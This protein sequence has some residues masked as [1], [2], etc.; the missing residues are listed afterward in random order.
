[1]ICY[2]KIKRG[3]N[4]TGKKRDGYPWQVFI[5]DNK[6]LFNVVAVV[7]KIEARRNRAKEFSIVIHTATIRTFGRNDI[8][9]VI[10]ST[11]SSYALSYYYGFA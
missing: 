9:L 1:V 8:D 3:N 4:R 10:N 6:R 2:E 5:R 11:F 7:D